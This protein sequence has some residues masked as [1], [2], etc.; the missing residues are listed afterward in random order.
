[1]TGATL[2]TDLRA[3]LSHAYGWDRRRIEVDTGPPVPGLLVFSAYERGAGGRRVTG[4]F[5]GALQTDYPANADVVLRALG[6]GTA[7][8]ALAVTLAAAVGML[9]AN[10]GAPFVDDFLI[11]HSIAADRITMPYV[12]ERA[13]RPALVYW[14]SSA[15]LSPWKTVIVARA[16]GT[17]DHHRDPV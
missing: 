10:P 1:M 8:T 11:E 15:E 12:T 9:E 3:S 5:D 13:G 16:D 14:N 2:E 4:V 6:F 7:G 17:F